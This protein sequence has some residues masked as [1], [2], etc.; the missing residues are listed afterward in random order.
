[1]NFKKSL[2][3][4]SMIILMIASIPN[5]VFATVVTDEKDKLHLGIT[6]LNDN[7]WGYSIGDPKT[8]GATGNAHKI[9][10]ILE[11]VSSQDGA[12]LKANGNKNIY[13]VNA[14]VGFGDADSTGIK[15][16]T[17]NVFFDMKTEREKI[18]AQN[19][20]LK[21]LVEGTIPGNDTATTISRYNALLALSDML[22]L[23]E[24]SEENKTAI[25]EAAG[26][27]YLESEDRYYYVDN[28]QCT[29]DVLITDDDIK[30]VQQAAIWYFTNYYEVE[31]TASQSYTET[32][33]HSMKYD[34]TANTGWLNYTLDGTN[35]ED[36]SNYNKATEEG[37]D[38]NQQA[39][40]LYNYLI[41]TAKS[42]ANKYSSSSSVG[43]TSSVPAQVTTQTLQYEELG[44][45]YVVGPI[46]IT[47]SEG[48]TT[49]YTIDFDVKVNGAKTENYKIVTD[50]NDITKETTIE[51]SVGQDVYVIVA[52][53]STTSITVSIDISYTDTTLTLWTS[54]TNG[55]GTQPVMI[56]EKDPQTVEWEKTVTPDS[57][58]FDLALRKYI[59]KIKKVDGNEVSYTRT[60]NVDES[61]ITSDTTTATYKHRKDPVLVETGDIVTY[62][63]T[64]YNEGQ[65]DGR[66][67]KVVDQLPTGLKFSKV[68]SG[69]F[70]LGSYD[71]TNN[72]VNLVRKA[73]NTTNLPAYVEGNLTSGKGSET[74]EIECEVIATPHQTDNKILTNVAW[75][76]EEIDADGNVITNQDGLDIDSE[77]S[78][79]PDVNKDNMENYT[80][81]ADNKKEDLDDE[82]YY[83][84]GQQ[85][86]DDFE[87]LMLMPESFDLKLIKRITAVNNQNVPERIEK[88]D[89]SKLNTI[90]EDGKLVTTADYK[91]NKTPVS[92][93][94]G[95]IVTYTFR[96]YNEGTIDGYATEITED[97]PEGLE[98]LWNDGIEYNADG[99]INWDNVTKEFTDEEKEAIEF[100]FNNGWSYAGDSTLRTIKTDYLSR[101]NETIPG[102]GS[103]LIKAF[104]NNDETKTEADI[105]YKEVSVKLKVISEDVTG[106]IIRNEACISEDTNKNGDPVDDRDSNTENWKKYE[107]DEDFDNIILKAFDL[108]LRK[109]IIAVS[110]DTEIENEEY[111][112]DENGLYTRAPS[113]D[114]SKLNT[115]GEDGKLITTAIYNHTKEPVMVQKNDI[116]VYMLRVYNEGEIDGYAAEIKDHLPPHLEFVE[117]EF[118]EKYGWEV[119]EDGRTVTTDYL[120]DEKIK[121]AQEIQIDGG[122]NSN[123]RYKLTYKEVPIMCKVK[124][125]AKSD[126]NITNIADITEYLDENKESVND[127]DS[128]E[129]NVV[130]PE[131]DKLPSYKDDETGEY[132]PGQ[133][134]DDDFEKIIV[135]EFDLAL[136]KWVTQAIVIDKNGETITETGHQ[137]Y[138]DPEQVV[139]VELHRKKYNQVTVKFR[140]SIRVINE[141]DIAGYAK[142]V[143]DYVPEGLKFVAEDNKGWTDEGNNVI[144]TRL[145]ENTLLQPGEYADVE[146]VLTWINSQDNMGVMINTAEISEDY[147]DYDVPDRDSTP[148]NQKPGEDDIDDAPVML[149]ISTGQMRIYFTLGFVVLITIAGGIVLIKKYVL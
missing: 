38:R 6:E 97:I 145:L 105:S 120:K 126:E 52:K 93:K 60:P 48:N 4:I 56:P 55:N 122:P 24:D 82:G 132:I 44:A 85:D 27:K 43:T 103:N 21:A 124:D 107:D 50:K 77:P 19:D 149:T 49:L 11:Y 16:D 125:T 36:L 136:R 123:E 100:N 135:K 66:A 111:L 62:K 117:G 104:G 92:V 34:K 116:V 70:E 90:G 58:V 3:S 95:D 7:N 119:S 25:L 89:V 59:T 80:G 23:A 139:K 20:V 18:K 1:M 102:D 129:D 68:V 83:Y 147:N 8:N 81:N 53:D 88:V 41:K 112:K 121:A 115:I 110:D 78:T 114:T 61:T 133:Q 99:S 65:K 37:S 137:P 73:S 22:Y 69:N 12:E 113:V 91:L 130:L 39:E 148:D 87:K 108:S 106:T 29:W 134:D 72:T 96:I 143:T 75:I 74:I 141:G 142:E 9:W 64:I 98:Y 40:I 57:K 94:Q 131:D 13:C 15:R 33:T 47:E 146:V 26:I 144:S 14:G 86:D 128:Q 71:E 17:Y 42:N 35:Y 46:K 127:R 63:L 30:A 118:N 138:D 109:F 45:N 5:L 101:D 54:A 10:N 84:K 76:S 51:D 28:N 32:T 140:Y 67:T 2:L 79:K 31:S